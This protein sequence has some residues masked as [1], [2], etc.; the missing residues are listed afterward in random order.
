MNQI[1]NAVASLL[2]DPNFC[3]D[4]WA[5]LDTELNNWEAEGVLAEFWWR[6]DDV[7]KPSPALDMLLSASRD[8]PI[9][10]AAIPNL[11]TVNLAEFLNQ[12]D[13]LQ[14]ISI[15]QHGFNHINHAPDTEKKAEFRNHRPTS[16]MQQD[17]S[18]GY[19]TLKELFKH[20]FVPLFVPPWNRIG[21]QAEEL[22]AQIGLEFLSTFTPR[23]PI[24]GPRIVNTHIDPVNW[25]A[26]KTFLGLGPTIAQA[27]IHLKAKREVW[28]TIDMIEPT[29]FLTHHLIHDEETWQFISDFNRFVSSHKSAL[30]LDMQDYISNFSDFGSLIQPD[31]HH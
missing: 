7:C 6:D 9:T 31:T 16:E 28:P 19:E 5:A 25:R 2:E 27:V 1:K 26:N 11:T 18:K 3:K 20:R 8:T 10:L 23:E 14:R 22:L 17:L 24:K 13:M 30:W 29:G 12:T 4:P 15:A 21:D